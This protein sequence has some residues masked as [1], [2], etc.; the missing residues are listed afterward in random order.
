MVCHSASTIAG[1]AADIGLCT[2]IRIVQTIWAWFFILV[3][4]F[5]Y[6]PNSVV[7]KPVGAVWGPLVSRPF[8]K[9]PWLVRLTLGWAA[10]LAIVFGSAFGFPL[11]VGEPYLSKFARFP[12]PDFPKG[13]QLR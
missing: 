7:T 1:P 5:R 2:S 11:A 9:L 13:D 6:I 3:I 4:A 10:L 12:D 8:F